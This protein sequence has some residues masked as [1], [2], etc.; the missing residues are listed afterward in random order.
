MCMLPHLVPCLQRYLHSILDAQH[1]QSSLRRRTSTMMQAA[2]VPFGLL[3]ASSVLAQEVPPPSYSAAVSQLS[4]ASAAFSA[5]M[6]PSPQATA[7]QG[8]SAA[9]TQREQGVG[10]AC[11]GSLARAALQS[12]GGAGRG[13]EKAGGEHLGQQG[14]EAAGQPGLGLQILV[15][16]G[17]T[18]F[19][20]PSGPAS[21]HAA[22]ACAITPVGR[23]G[24]CR[25]HS[26]CLEPQT[27][28][29]RMQ[30]DAQ[31]PEHA[32]DCEMLWASMRRLKGAEGAADCH[33]P[34]QGAS[35]MLRQSRPRFSEDCCRK[36]SCILSAADAAF[37]KSL[38]H[39][40]QQ[41]MVVLQSSVR[42]P[43]Q[44]QSW[45]MLKVDGNTTAEWKRGAPVERAALLGP[46]VRHKVHELPAGVPAQLQHARL[47]L[48][49]MPAVHAACRQ[50]G[51]LSGCIAPAADTKAHK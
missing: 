10:S 17:A 48:Q 31:P 33:S 39:S 43:T 7:L 8:D 22:G 32:A 28:D 38:H 20:V 50:R 14:S 11:K 24:A 51:A 29:S 21:P 41:T 13:G 37:R 25:A 26:H 49:L 19:G 1:M 47:H 16:D 36:A 44:C 18:A 12:W 3:L 35:S 23:G 4:T 34:G 15:R 6:H 27:Q 5:C 45:L 46:E 2:A 9:W 42:M 30:A 40:L